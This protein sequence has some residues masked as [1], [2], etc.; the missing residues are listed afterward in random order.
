MPL[1][2]HGWSKHSVATT[3][4]ENMGCSFSHSQDCIFRLNSEP[5][6]YFRTSLWTDYRR[7]MK[8]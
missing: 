6:N 2:Q 4:H 1:N 7:A 3:V 5:E 8:V